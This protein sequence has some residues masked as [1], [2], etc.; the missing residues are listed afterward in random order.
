MW[1]GNGPFRHLPP[2]ERP[3][4]LYGPGSCWTLGYWGRATTPPPVAPGVTDVQVLQRQ[5]EII[6]AQLE[7]LRTAL[8]DIEKKLR[9]LSEE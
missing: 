4:W 5:K 2:W 9:E 1:P 7:S 8:A 3:G 6:E